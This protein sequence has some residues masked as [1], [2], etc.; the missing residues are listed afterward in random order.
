MANAL[1]HRGPDGEGSFA[2]E[3]GVALGHRRLAI[4]DLSDAGI[5]PF[6]SDDGA[7][8]LLHNGEIYNYLE[9][10]HELE[11]RGHR[12]RTR[13]R[14]RGRARRLRGVGRPLRRA[15]QRH[16][17]VR[18][19]GRQARAALLLARPLR[20][21]AVLLPLRRRPLRVRE[22]AE[23]VPRRLVDR[24]CSRT[25][26]RSATTSSRAH[27]TT[28]TRRSSTGSA[29]CRPRTRSSSTARGCAF[30]PLLARSSRGTP[31]ATRSASVPRA[32]PRLGP[33]A[34]AQRR[35]VGTCL[36]GGARLLRDRVHDRP[37]ARHRDRER[38]AGR[39]PAANVHGVL[40]GRG[41][42][43]A[44]VRATRSCA[45]TVADP[46]WVSFDDEDARRVPPGDRRRP[47]T[48]RSARRA[49]SRSGS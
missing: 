16:V 18:A 41:L 24:R 11:A 19:L 12:F 23:G 40:R 48:S 3:P 45:Q 10:R 29:S 4:I 46:H 42:R 27:S 2:A 43:R 28:A 38:A 13:D 5:Q 8:Q 34:A 1:A 14:H 36:S 9:L 32:V 21:Q 37:P 7:L 25:S 30:E 44:P 33:A 39:R 26:P 31:R 15:L 17:G 47:R 49:S 20:R 6:A 22:R 35:P